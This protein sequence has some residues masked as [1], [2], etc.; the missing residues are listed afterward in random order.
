[1]KVQLRTVV[2]AATVAALA[3]FGIAAGAL[4]APASVS[5]SPS[6]T[7]VDLSTPIDEGQT[8]TVS[9]TFSAPDPSGFPMIT[10][11]WGNGMA[12]DT[13][14]PALG[15]NTFS[16]SMLFKDEGAFTVTLTLDD[17][18]NAPAVQTLSLV[19]RNVAPTVTMSTSAATL[20]DHDTLSVSGSFTD[21]GVL[22]TFTATINWGD[23]SASWTQ[24]YT[25]NA[26]KTFA[27]SH[28]YL[29]AG[30]YTVTAT[31]T[32][33]DNG[34]GSATANL[35]VNA[36]NTPPS[37]VVLA[38]TPAT[39]GSATGVS[40][41]FTDPDAAD[42]H[43]V[44]LAWGDGSSSTLA[45]AAGVLDFSS[46]H[47]YATA[48]DYNV[49]ATVTDP[50]GASASGSV[51]FTVAR[52]NSAPTDLVLTTTGTVVG[53]SGSVSGTFTDADA[54]DTH[55][56][57]IDWGDGSPVV[58][59][60]L[61]AGVGS[62]GASHTYTAVGTYTVTVDV[63]D[64]S[65]A[66]VAG[67]ATLVVRSETSSELLGDL[68][69]MIKSWSLDA[70]M[71]TSLLTKVK[72]SCT[73]LSALANEVSA[74]AGKELTATEVTAFNGTNSQLGTQ[75]GCTGTLTAAMR[76]QATRAH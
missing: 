35:V 65:N 13:V 66:W 41:K 54:T 28:Q 44:A 7:T 29:T 38:A 51:S 64:P 9:G 37:N 62:F 52:P 15:D 63:V 58:D 50:A 2:A 34:A 16:F 39:A 69:T 71:Q 43:T 22:D 60:A 24:N 5:L 67:S 6:F 23:L 76:A 72:A 31:V 14:S 3:T 74:Q 47:T 26:A 40:G 17:G 59:L 68:T 53:G 1:M 10:V 8:A 70:G 45:L 12:P 11:D 48:G 57:S 46:S 25:A 73:S 49:T 56:V 21:P 55:T 20:L 42:T 33:D 4:A 30:T 32:D 19:V 18:V 75:L 61:D 36:R 27:A